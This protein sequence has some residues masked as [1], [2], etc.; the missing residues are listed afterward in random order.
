MK[1]VNHRKGEFRPR[2]SEYESCDK[3]VMVCMLR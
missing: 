1:A 2:K 3:I